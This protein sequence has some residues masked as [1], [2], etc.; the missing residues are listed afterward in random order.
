MNTTTLT[1]SSDAEPPRDAEESDED[2]EED[3][4]EVEAEAQDN[5]S[6][7]ALDTA[8]SAAPR[9][10]CTVIKAVPNLQSLSGLRELGH[11]AICWQL[12]SAK[13]GNGVEQLRD[14][15]DSYWQSDGNSQP[16][17]I[18]V[19]FARR[20]SLSHVCLY[21]DY[22]LDESYTPRRI[23]VSVGMT[24][25]E[26]VDAMRV[27]EVQEPNGWCILPLDLFE[28]CV[29]KTHVVRISILS[30]HQNGR[31]THV[32]LVRLFGPRNGTRSAMPPF[33]NEQLENSHV[34]TEENVETVQEEPYVRSSSGIMVTPFA[35]IR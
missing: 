30:M 17:W 28:D 26:L 12:S 7:P 27:V 35:V 31:D 10:D 2:E 29:I 32:R 22:T 1:P 5:D 9:D 23:Q 14:G 3:D 25:H 19:H 4:D 24:N 11:D 21:L 33:L 6:L 34:S 18:Q 8:P 20:M 13:P 15:L 16:H